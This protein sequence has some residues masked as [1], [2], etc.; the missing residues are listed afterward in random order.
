MKNQDK[1]SDET[2]TGYK[3]GD[4]INQTD[5]Q[6]IEELLKTS[7]IGVNGKDYCNLIGSC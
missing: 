6:N 4:S 7:G 2:N 5:L 3:N 1:E